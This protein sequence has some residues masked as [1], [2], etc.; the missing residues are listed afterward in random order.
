MRATIAGAAVALLA[1][2][3]GSGGSGSSG[4]QTRTVLVD[5]R[6][7][8]VETSMFDYFPR[9]LAVRPGDTVEFK[10]AWTGEPHSVTMGTFVDEKIK[11]LI[12]LFDRVT[13]EGKLPE[14]EPEEF[15]AFG[16]ALPFAFGEAGMAQN[17]AQPCYV[18]A[19]GFDGKYPGD[20]KTPCAKR[21]Q[22]AFNG[23]QAI[24]NSGVI[25]YEGVGGNTFTVKLAD[26][27]AP[28]TYTYYCNVH[29]P[30]QYGQLAVQEKGTDIPSRA[31]VAR[32]ARAEAEKRTAPLLRNFRA[33]KQGSVVQGGDAGEVKID[34]GKS[35]LIG[36]PTPIFADQQLVHGIVNEFVPEELEARVGQKVT[37]TFTGGHTISFNVPK[38]FPVFTVA[39][40]GTVEYN[41]KAQ[42][43]AGGWPDRPKPPGAEHDREGPPPPPVKVD[44]G[45][46]DG[47]GFR[48]TGLN[49]Q[50][51][52]EFSVTFTRAGTYDY[53][54]LIH[55][56]MVGKV[57]VRS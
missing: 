30:L 7:D 16:Q 32:Q 13:R 20:E 2:A 38:Y 57:V 49:Y 23:R 10:Q 47:R 15:A 35:N 55:P 5:Y 45:P 39:K 54:C 22:P 51:Q 1:A 18:D 44:A 43:P 25:P 37:W 42:E 40:D 12:E 50:D 33:A 36:V 26:D 46:W 4:P 56:Q 19:A 24:Y 28:G 17:A 53:A 29:G 41:R 14:G 6:H 8:E 3:C 52:D 11:P 31:E 9:R 21:P 34:A 27:L 48:S